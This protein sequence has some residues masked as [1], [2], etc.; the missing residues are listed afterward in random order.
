MLDEF[1]I[2]PRRFEGF[3]REMGAILRRHHVAAV[4]VSIRHSPAD[5][6]AL[7]PWA[8]EEVFSFVLFYRQGLDLP[9]QR[10]VGEWTRELIERDA[11]ARGAL[12]P[13]VPAARHARAVRARLP[14]SRAAAPAQVTRRSAGTLQQLALAEVPLIPSLA[15]HPLFANVSAAA[16]AQL[17]QHLEIR[18]FGAG[19]IV[20][21]AGV[22]SAEL[23]GL[24]E[25]AV[26]IELGDGGRRL[27]LVAPQ[28]FG[29]LSALTGDPVSATV[30]AHRDV[31]AWVLAAPVLFEAMAQE[32]A[33]FRNVAT[34]LGMRLRERT[35]RAP[36]RRPRVA[37]LPMREDGDRLLLAAL[38]RG[39]HHYA[40]GSEHDAVPGDDIAGGAGR[41]RRWRDEG[42]GDAVLLLGVGLAGCAALLSDLD[43]DDMLLVADDDLPG[44][45]HALAATHRLAARAALGGGGLAALVR[46]PCRAKRSRPAPRASDWS[47]ERQPALDHLVRRL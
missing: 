35:R 23:F 19:D 3:V 4:N 7:L 16:L 36:T 46:M 26:R 39:L 24:I 29:E 33:F 5:A 9:A 28:C 12:L 43:A 44:L 14:R 2:P 38:G 22:E 11:A 10:A 30:V 27:Q 6:L 31:R 40:P 32:T 47:R 8:R 41:M 17:E 42:H 15:L 37:L 20:L 25:G 34:L 13:A 21:R 45:P 18:R 1:F